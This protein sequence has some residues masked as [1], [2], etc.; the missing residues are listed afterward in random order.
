VHRAQAIEELFNGCALEMGMGHKGAV[1][2]RF[3]QKGPL[4]ETCQHDLVPAIPTSFLNP[5][6]N[7]H[8]ATNDDDGDNGE[9]LSQY[10]GAIT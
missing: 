9:G 1:K 3:P 8:S 5:F 2:T 4:D 7:N 10:R 6:H